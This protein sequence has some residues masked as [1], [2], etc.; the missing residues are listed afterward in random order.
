MT[1]VSSL[2]ELQNPAY[3]DTAFFFNMDYKKIIEFFEK[4]LWRISEGDVSPFRFLWLEVLTGK[5]AKGCTFMPE[6]MTDEQRKITQK[7]AHKVA[8]KPVIK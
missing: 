3:S 7:V 6:K 8:K 4:D 2:E 5:S 1:G